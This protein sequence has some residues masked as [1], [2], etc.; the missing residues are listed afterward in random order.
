MDLLEKILCNPTEDEEYLT[1]KEKMDRR[2]V[3]WLLGGEIKSPNGQI[4]DKP[5]IG[6]KRT[7][8]VITKLDMNKDGD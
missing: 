6:E 8:A 5:I 2:A 3:N 7:I 1:E 4:G